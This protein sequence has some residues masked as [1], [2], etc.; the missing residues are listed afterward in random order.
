MAAATE[1]LKSTAPPYSRLN[2]PL[3]DVC[4]F[5]SFATLKQRLTEI[6]PYL[7]FLKPEFLD[8][9]SEICDVEEA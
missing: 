9:L 1:S 8:E 7:R 4:R 3:V 2:P 5:V 6:S